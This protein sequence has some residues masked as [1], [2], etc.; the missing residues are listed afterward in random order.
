MRPINL[1]RFIPARV[2][3]GG[4]GLIGAILFAAACN[5]AGWSGGL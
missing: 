3:V 1:S 4:L 2:L 5:A